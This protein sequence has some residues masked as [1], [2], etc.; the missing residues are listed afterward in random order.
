MDNQKD[1]QVLMV[2]RINIVKKVIIDNRTNL[3]SYPY[4]SILDIK[5]LHPLT[6]KV[7]RKIR[8]INLYDNKV[9]RKQV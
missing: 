1:M 6:R 2:V 5:E 7:L 8:V 9:G 4:C 3:V